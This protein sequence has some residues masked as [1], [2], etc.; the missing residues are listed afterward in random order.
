MSQLRNT[1]PALL[2]IGIGYYGYQYVYKVKHSGP[3]QVDDGITVVKPWKV[4]TNFREICSITVLLDY[5]R[6]CNGD[7]RVQYS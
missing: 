2:S 3:L 1:V 6:L 5:C 4:L 7:I